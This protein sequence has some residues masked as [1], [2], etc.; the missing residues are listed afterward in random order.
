MHPDLAAV[1]AACSLYID[2]DP[3]TLLRE[4]GQQTG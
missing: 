4:V 2:T 3:Q 1:L